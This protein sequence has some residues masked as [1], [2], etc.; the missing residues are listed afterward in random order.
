[1]AEAERRL[2]NK[3]SSPLLGSRI[4]VQSTRIFVSHLLQII[5]SSQLINTCKPSFERHV[6]NC[7]PSGGAEGC[8]SSREPL[9]RRAPSR[10]RLWSPVAAKALDSNTRR[11]HA[12]ASCSRSDGVCTGYIEIPYA[13]AGFAAQRSAYTAH[14]Q[15]YEGAAACCLSASEA[16]PRLG[17]AALVRC[18][19]TVR[20]AQRV[21][22]RV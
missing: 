17:F 16:R 7:C 15:H 9:N 13:V 4:I 14:V 8:N 22:R 2:A 5:L 21:R 20:R 1:M 12:R 6:Q 18:R 19:A 3:E 11:T 10:T